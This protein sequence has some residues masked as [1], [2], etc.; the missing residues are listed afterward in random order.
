MRTYQGLKL[1][2]YFPFNFYLPFGFSNI[3]SLVSGGCQGGDTKIRTEASLGVVR[4]NMAEFSHDSY[5]HPL[6]LKLALAFIC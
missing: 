1:R 5:M 6:E 2:T 3:G 4:P